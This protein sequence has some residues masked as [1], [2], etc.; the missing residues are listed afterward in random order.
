MNR[1]I[2][3]SGTKYLLGMHRI[4][5]CLND[6]TCSGNMKGEDTVYKTQVPILKQ[7]NAPVALY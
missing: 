5:P 3:I 6:A 7:L 1:N 2:V 4:G